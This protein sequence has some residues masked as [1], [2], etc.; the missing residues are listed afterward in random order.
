MASSFV[1][2]LQFVLFSWPHGKIAA[3]F[4]N[5]IGVVIFAYRVWTICNSIK[6]NIQGFT[7]LVTW[8]LVNGRGNHS[9]FQKL[10]GSRSTVIGN[11]G[12]LTSAFCNGTAGCAYAGC[13]EIKGIDF[14]IFFQNLT[15]D[16]ITLYIIV[17][18]VG[19]SSQNLDNCPGD[20]SGI[21]HYAV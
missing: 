12:D 2:S 16:Q 20:N 14:R 17:T 15:G 1:R 21:R 6:Q 9:G 8:F 19:N 4:D 10:L 13:R 3:D 7:S 5:G 11:Y 18:V